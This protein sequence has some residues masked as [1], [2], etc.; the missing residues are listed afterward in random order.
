MFEVRTTCRSCGGGNLKQVLDLGNQPL[1]NSLL[2]SKDAPEDTYPLTLVWCPNCTLVQI[3]ETVDPEKL[4]SHYVYFSSQSKTMVESARNCVDDV[5]E[6]EKLGKNSF[7]MEL[8]SNDG[9]LLQHYRN[10]GIPHVGVDPAKNVAEEANRNGIRTLPEFF[11]A[12]FAKQ[13]E[14]Q[15]DVLHANNVLAHV[16]DTLGF[17]EGIA[18]VLRPNGVAVIEVPY[19]GSLIDNAEFDTIYHE[20]LCYF[21][22]Y[23]MSRL[24]NQKGLTIQRVESL[25]IHGGSIRV[26]ARKQGSVF[27]RHPDVW[28]LLDE[29]AKRGFYKE[30]YYSNFQWR[31]DDMMELFWERMK[32]YSFF[33]GPI[34]CYGAAAK[35]NTRLNYPHPDYAK[36]ILSFVADSTPAKQGL[37]T[38]GMRLEVVSPEKFREA[39][40]PVALILAWNFA[41][42]IAKKEQAYTR[43][44]GIFLVPDEKKG[45]RQL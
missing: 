45:I 24:L 43:S 40:P 11:T 9:Y 39:N 15:V 12:E 37:F 44:G 22:V 28:T 34:A 16:A 2:A 19:I 36:Y 30:S 25:P 32:T 31:V 4:F 35:G 13:F 21:S 14:G 8:A 10:A 7:V 42:E 3:R 18:T 26:F 41:D 33:Y 20:H 27:S 5:I 6:Q 38:P 29:E 1:V 17:V 23:S